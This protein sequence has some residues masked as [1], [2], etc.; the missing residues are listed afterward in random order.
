MSCVQSALP[1]Y[2]RRWVLSSLRHSGLG[3]RGRL[4]RCLRPPAK[5][6]CYRAVTLTSNAG[7][8]IRA[9]RRDAE[10]M[11]PGRSRSPNRNKRSAG[12][13]KRAPA[14]QG[15]KRLKNEARG[16]C[17]WGARLCPTD[18]FSASAAGSAGFPA[19]GFAE[20]SSSAMVSVRTGDWKVPRTRRQECLRYGAK[21]VRVQRTSRS[22]AEGGGATDQLQPSAPCNAA[23]TGASPTVALRARG[24]RGAFPVGS[25]PAGRYSRRHL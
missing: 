20:L 18:L 24:R 8:Q 11:R 12:G 13:S 6:A 17:D 23:A 5:G 1:G 3:E 4:A 16:G 22:T 10:W 15:S 14:V 9:I 19:C 7:S 25:M 2:A 21:Q